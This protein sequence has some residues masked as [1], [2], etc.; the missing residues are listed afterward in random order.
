MLKKSELCDVIRKVG[1]YIFKLSNFI[2]NN[3][4]IQYSEEIYNFIMNMHNEILTDHNETKNKQPYIIKILLKMHVS[5]KHI[6]II[7]IKGYAKS[8][9]S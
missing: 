8:N 6:I 4:I 1:A 2:E 7:L 9:Q 3:E 5:L